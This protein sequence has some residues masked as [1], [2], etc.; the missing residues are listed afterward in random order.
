MIIAIDEAI[1]MDSMNQHH[2][3]SIKYFPIEFDISPSQ[4]VIRRIYMSEIV[5]QIM[6]CTDWNY[7]LYAKSNQTDHRAL[8]EIGC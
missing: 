5:Y 6:Y 3:I 7:R 4:S 2:Q 1:N 8:Y